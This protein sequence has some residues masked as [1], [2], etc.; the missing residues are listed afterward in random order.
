[1][2]GSRKAAGGE[3]PAAGEDGVMNGTIPERIVAALEELA[4][5]LGVRCAEGRDRTLDAHE[6]AVLERV[7]AALPKLLRAVVEAA[8]TG[9]DPRL[10]RA[11]QA[12]PGCGAKRRPRTSAKRPSCWPS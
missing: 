6:R 12:C 3:A 11:R 8:T 4:E 7:R 9:L 5:E 10:A 1:V 2:R